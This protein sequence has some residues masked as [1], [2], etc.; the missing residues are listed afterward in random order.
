MF[1]PHIVPHV[2]NTPLHNVICLIHCIIEWVNCITEKFAK[3]IQLHCE[4]KKSCQQMKE[5]AGPLKVS[6]V[7]EK[8]NIYKEDL[9]NRITS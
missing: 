2:D 9:M 4:F 5:G 3:I 7:G 1:V 8:G 6:G